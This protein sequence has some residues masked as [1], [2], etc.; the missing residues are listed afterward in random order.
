M[1]DR[2]VRVELMG[3]LKVPED[4]TT[5]ETFKTWPGLLPAL[6]AFEDTVGLI[7]SFTLE[8]MYPGFTPPDWTTKE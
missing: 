5:V 1:A 2:Y 4:E 7:R 6:A 8:L 3:Y